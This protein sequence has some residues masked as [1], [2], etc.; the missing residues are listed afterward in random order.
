MTTFQFTVPERMADKIDVVFQDDSML[1]IN[2]PAGLLSIPDRF[3]TNAPHV[4]T[5]LE[6][7]YGKLFT[8]HRLDKF[9]SGLIVLAKSE[10]AHKLLSETFELRKITKKYVAIIHGVLPQSQGS[11]ELAIAEDP[12]QKGKY[13]VHP[14]GKKSRTDFL[15]LEAWRN[16]SLVELNIFSG[17]THQI[18]VHLSHL[19]H[20][21]VADALY[22]ASDQLMLSAIKGKRYQLNKSGEEKPILSRQALHASS[23]EFRH[24]ISE[25]ELHLEAPMPKDMTATVKQI[26]KW[27]R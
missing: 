6:P 1:V 23:L 15:V 11:I 9:T 14:K 10:I 19:G 17:R 26:S 2:K 12:T 27:D 18:R 13:K 5:L 4:K 21:I 16:Y 24:P 22:A 7:K 25:K 20:P 8:V 3:N